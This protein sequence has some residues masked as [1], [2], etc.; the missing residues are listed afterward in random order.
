MGDLGSTT[1][2]T[3]VRVMPQSLGSS[4]TPQ[5]L[6]AFDKPLNISGLHLSCK[7][8]ADIFLGPLRPARGPAH[9]T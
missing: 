8:G 4:P 1:W 2:R 3:R 7:A 6:G 9:M 5:W